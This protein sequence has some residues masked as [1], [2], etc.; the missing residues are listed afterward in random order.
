MG[1]FPESNEQRQQRVNQERR[2]EDR[3][4]R[5]TQQLRK[6]KQRAEFQK[7]IDDE[8]EKNMHDASPEM[9]QKRLAE[10]KN[11]SVL[12]NQAFGQEN[13]DRKMRGAPSWMK[14]PG[15]KMVDALGAKLKEKDEADKIGTQQM[16]TLKRPL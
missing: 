5:R 16:I 7:K 11:S 8:V 12:M 15:M 4:R 6:R 1:W 9:R 3:Q 14:T 2:D 10:L 13:A